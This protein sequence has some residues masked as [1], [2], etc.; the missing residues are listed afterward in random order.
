[1]KIRNTL[2]NERGSSL[3]EFVLYGLV[4]Q[5]L[6]LSLFLQLAT[7]QNQQLAAESIARHGLREFILAE[8]NP[9]D[10]A[11]QISNDF[12]LKAIP[13]ISLRCDPDCSSPL[14]KLL[15]NVDV[16]GAK[17]SSVFIR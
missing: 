14:S 15:F 8:T 4:L 9:M 10:V 2:T 17:A 3:I 12:H 6:V 13:E 11:R 1:M 7:W 16:A 5:V